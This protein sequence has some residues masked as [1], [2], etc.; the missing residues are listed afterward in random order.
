M[1]KTSI[2]YKYTRAADD[3]IEDESEA[4]DWRGGITTFGGLRCVVELESERN[5]FADD[6]TGKARVKCRFASGARGG[7]SRESRR[8]AS[9]LRYPEALIA[10]TVD[11]YACM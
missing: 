1:D 8:D 11:R 7:S 9:L 3:R 5:F 10:D 6:G 2:Q 4:D